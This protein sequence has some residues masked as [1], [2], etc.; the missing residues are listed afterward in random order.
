MSGPLLIALTGLPATGK[1]T[2]ARGL[3][4]RLGAVH[5][6]IDTIEQALKSSVFAPVEEV[7]DHGYLV[8]WG[9]ARDN[10]SIGQVVIGD[11]V[12]GVPE[13]RAGWQ[14]AARDV[15]P[16]VTLW[17]TCSDAV[18]HRARAEGRASDIPGLT[19]PDWPEIEAR[20]F[21]PCPEA[22]ATLD[23]AGQTPAESLETALHL[24][25]PHL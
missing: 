8:A 6:R 4:A 22:T 7:I 12:N 16:I 15:A 21:H 14:A 11:S 25:A 17:V 2:L 23:T 20:E 13:T 18:S 9:V 1:S 19:Y 24:L 3:A 5:L 10:L